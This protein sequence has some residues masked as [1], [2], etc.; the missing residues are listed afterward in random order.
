MNTNRTRRPSS[1][2]L[3]DVMPALVRGVYPH[4]H[5][6]PRRGIAEPL[7][8][9]YPPGSRPVRLG[10]AAPPLDGTPPSGSQ[11]RE[12]RK[13][14]HR[15]GRLVHIPGTQHGAHPPIQFVIVE[16]PQRVVLAEQRDQPLAVGLIR[17]PPR[18][19]GRETRHT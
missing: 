19:T 16:L 11:P 12:P 10:V 8:R 4:P 1:I 9:R 13:V 6:R 14:R 3:G 5:D 15:Q 17:Q 18:T 7:I 2:W